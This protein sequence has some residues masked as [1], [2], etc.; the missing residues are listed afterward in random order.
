[1]KMV[2]I[3]PMGTPLITSY[4]TH[5]NI[6]ACINDNEHVMQWF[7]NHYVQLMGG[8][9]LTHGCFIDFCAP[10]AW[11]TCPG[12]EYQVISRQWLDIWGK[13]I[14]E[15]MLNCIQTGWYVFMHLDQ[16]Y[17]PGSKAYGQ[18]HVVHDTFVFGY[19][20][21]RNRFHT[22]DFYQDSIYG[23]ST[24]DFRQME[25]SFRAKA[26]GPISDQLQGIILVKPKEQ[27]YYRFDIQVL[28]K[29]M[30]A[31]LQSNLHGKSYTDGYRNDIGDSRDLWVYGLQVY[32][33]LYENMERYGE[34]RAEL[35]PYEVLKD[36]KR[37]MLE[38][39][40]FLSKQNLLARGTI[41][42]AQCN[43]L[44]EQSLLLR[45]LAI[46]HSIVRSRS[47]L[48]KMID[49]LM[50]LRTK[51]EVI[52]MDILSCLAETRSNEASLENRKLTLQ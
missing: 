39:I 16:F 8:K 46:K 33:L 12:L 30:E 32:D 40:R 17:I 14:V 47:T 29:Y 1:M 42:E 35:T 9:D 43:K 38:R 50:E 28:C 36:H 15:F 22:A 21:W 10:L 34:N 52:W 31:Y 45:N 49:I 5:A 3:L 23:H 26:Q 7:F 25:Q 44:Y 24:V 6:L 4:P 51:E 11:K 18:F 20:R 41:F 27:P 48:G 37:M 2:N 19:D 13:S